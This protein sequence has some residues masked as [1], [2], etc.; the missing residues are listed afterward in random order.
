MCSGYDKFVLPLFPLK[1]KLLSHSPE[2][3]GLNSPAWIH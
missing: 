2:K 1:M 3:H